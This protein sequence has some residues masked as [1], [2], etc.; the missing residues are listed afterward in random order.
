[1]SRE[2]LKSNV[3]LVCV[4]ALVVLALHPFSWYRWLVVT[5]LAIV[6]AGRLR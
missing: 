5:A 1:M 3:S 2:Q 4:A 6:V